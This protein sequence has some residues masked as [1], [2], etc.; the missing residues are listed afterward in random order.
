MNFTGIKYFLAIV[1]EGNISA[2]ARNLYISQ[3]AMSEQLKKL[4]QEVGTPL[5]SR[6]PFQLTAAGECFYAGCKELLSI[7]NGMMTEIESIRQ[8]RRRR[9]TIA[10]PTY[11]TQPYL[12]EF[13]GRFQTK[14]P[15]YEITVIKRLHTDI[16]HNMSGVDLYLSYLPLSPDLENDILL[17]SDPYYVTFQKALAERVYGSR[18]EDVERQLVRTRDLSVLREMPFILLRDKYGQVTQDL[19]DIFAEYRFKPIV[20]FNS[21]NYEMNHQTCYN[22]LGCLLATGSII[23]RSFY[24]NQGLNTGELLSYPIKV[25]AFETKMAISREKGKRLHTAEQ[26]FIAEFSEFMRE[27]QDFLAC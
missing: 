19:R 14:H 18:W 27:Q 23:K 15:E 2:A 11:C 16:A 22:G 10:V 20:S 25:T 7:Y 21:E 24:A 6:S 4:E 26:Q 17:E 3:Q 5:L 12:L 9:L 1:E 8:D 13:L